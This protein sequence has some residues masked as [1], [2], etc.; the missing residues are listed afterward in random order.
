MSVEGSRGD[1]C[2]SLCLHKSRD[3]FLSLF[4]NTGLKGSIFEQSGLVKDAPV[5]Y[6][7]RGDWIR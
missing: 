5:G 7:F 1:M 4:R 2:M 3:K 6:V